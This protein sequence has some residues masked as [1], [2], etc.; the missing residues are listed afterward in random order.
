MAVT[1]GCAPTISAY[2]HISS[3]PPASRLTSG[4]RGP[5]RPTPGQAISTQRPPLNSSTR[6]YVTEMGVR[7][8][9]QR[10]RS[11]N[12]LTSG[13]FIHQRRGRPQR[14]QWL[15]GRSTEPPRGNRHTTTLV[16]LPTARPSTRASNASD[17][18]GGPAI[19][20]AGGHPNGRGAG[21]ARGPWAEN[22]HREATPPTRRSTDPALWR[23]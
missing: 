4:G 16:K 15:P 23:R 12:Q 5:S 7:Q 14:G 3:R 9:P 11:S 2:P 13:T 19:S 1:D 20:G 21:G 22:A 6:G 17:G 10:P 18:S 8:K